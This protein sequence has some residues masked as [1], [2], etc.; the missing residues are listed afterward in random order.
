MIESPEGTLGE[1][2]IPRR[3]RGGKCSSDYRHHPL[4]SLLVSPLVPHVVAREPHGDGSPKR[5]SIQIGA[6]SRA[7]RVA[8]PGEV[9]LDQLRGFIEGQAVGELAD[10]CQASVHEQAV[11]VPDIAARDLPHLRELVGHAD[12][13]GDK[14]LVKLRTAV[15]VTFVILG[16]ACSRHCPYRSAAL[17]P[18]KAQPGS[19]YEVVAPVARGAF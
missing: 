12:A 15:N 14:V 5:L 3:R 2:S 16:T 11:P 6:V 13:R 4:P 19:G 17:P 7:R 10:Q 9:P 18:V 1:G 8:G